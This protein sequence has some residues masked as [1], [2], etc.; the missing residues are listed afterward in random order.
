M[1]FVVCFP[2]KVDSMEGCIY[3]VSHRTE[4]TCKDSLG[5]SSKRG[6]EE[7]AH[8]GALEV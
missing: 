3:S 4:G 1:G 2:L 5:L 7:G 6:R 8:E